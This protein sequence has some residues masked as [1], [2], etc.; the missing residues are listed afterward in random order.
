MNVAF[1][2]ADQ[3]LG[4][5]RSRGI[6]EYTEVLLAAL[7]RLPDLQFCLQTSLSSCSPKIPG[8]KV[9]ILP[10]RTDNSALRILADQIHP[11]WDDRSVDLWHYPKGYLCSI[12]PRSQPVIGTVHD[13]YIQYYADNYPE[14]RSR[15]N[16]AYWVRVL[17]WSISRFDA[18]ITD[19]K[20]SQRSIVA[21]CERYR[22]K[23][24]PIS[25]VYLAVEW[26]VIPTKVVKENFVLHLAS[27]EPHKRTEHLLKLWSMMV[28]SGRSLPELKL[29]GN[30]TQNQLR[31]ASEVPQ[32]Y[33]TTPLTRHELQA[34]MQSARSLILPSEIEGF[35]LPALEAYNT[36]TPVVYVRDTTVHEVL[37]FN[38]PGSFILSDLETFEAA[39]DE[40]LSLSGDEVSAIRKTLIIKYTWERTAQETA[41]V[42][43]QLVPDAH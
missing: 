4:R 33:I 29:V 31:L 21:L 43:R 36:M 3:N 42:Y 11:L 38:T 6:T 24:P 26:D 32:I 37:G 39:L 35:G 10:F 15:Y 14:H 25:V 17:R 19:S 30:L 23:C 1:Y 41:S 16:Y 28:K 2:L 27:P 5:D 12:L 18:I 9:C 8:A 22:I 20:F 7:S 13:T 34:L 40:V